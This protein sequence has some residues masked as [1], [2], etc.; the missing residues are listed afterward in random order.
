MPQKKK[1]KQPKNKQTKNNNKTQVWARSW[2]PRKR[3][4]KQGFRS[5]II[6]LPS[7]LNFSLGQLVDYVTQVSTLGWILGKGR[8]IKALPATR[9]ELLRSENTQRLVT[10]LG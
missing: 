6:F 4:S 7:V 2:G 9:W 1:K 3:S 5:Q 10:A 8:S